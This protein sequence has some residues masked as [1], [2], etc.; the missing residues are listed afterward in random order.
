VREK[1]DKTLGTGA[2]EQ[3]EDFLGNLLGGKKKK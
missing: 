3:V 1:I 2:S